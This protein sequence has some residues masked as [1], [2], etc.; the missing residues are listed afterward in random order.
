[1]VEIHCSYSDD[2]TKGFAS[3]GPLEDG[4]VIEFRARVTQ[5]TK[6]Y[7]GYRDD[8]YV[9]IETD[10]K[11]SRPTKVRIVSKSNKSEPVAIFYR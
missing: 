1:M 2:P 11:L 9:P 6:G 3:L 10:Y 7:K 8:V 5:Y 4:D